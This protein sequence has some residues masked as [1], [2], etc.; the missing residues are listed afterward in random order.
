VLNLTQKHSEPFVT[1]DQLKDNLRIMHNLED[2]LIERLASTA[3]LYVQ[4]V[5]GRKLNTDTYALELSPVVSGRINIPVSPI[6]SIDSFEYYDVD[7]TLQTLE[8]ENFKLFNSEDSTYLSA[9]DSWPVFYEREDAIK[10]TFSSGYPDNILFPENLKHAAILLASHWYENRSAVG[11]KMTD[12]P[13]GV[14][15]LINLSKVGW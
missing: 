5:S 11:D 6:L 13:H 2:Q 14:E 10:I 3:C 7:N 15:P 12:I 4:E 9:V 1:L 8:S